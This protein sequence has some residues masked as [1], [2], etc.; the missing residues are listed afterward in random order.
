M[1]K[2]IGTSIAVGHNDRSF[3]DLTG[4]RFNILN[5][6]SVQNK[7]VPCG[8][9]IGEMLY[10]GREGRRG[11]NLKGQL[12]KHERLALHQQAFYQRKRSDVST[13]GIEDCCNRRTSIGRGI[14]ADG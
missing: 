14:I 13:R 5:A 9:M 6:I 12:P 1:S 11:T 10:S 7:V 4:P 2:Y 3:N 8:F